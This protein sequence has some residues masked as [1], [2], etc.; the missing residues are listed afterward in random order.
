MQVTNFNPLTLSWKSFIS[1]SITDSDI[2]RIKANPC[3]YVVADFDLAA[4]LSYGL[5]LRRHLPFAY[6]T[7]YPLPGG[8]A[9]FAQ[10]MF[11][12]VVSDL[13]PGG[14]QYLDRSMKQIQERDTSRRKPPARNALR[15]GQSDVAEGA[16]EVVKLKGHARWVHFSLLDIFR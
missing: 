5:P 4:K 11:E 8:D 3:R 14:R 16:A 2:E 1:A 10:M 15:C 7:W 13:D 12:T 9:A 6:Q